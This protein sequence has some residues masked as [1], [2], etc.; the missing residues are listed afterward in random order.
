MIQTVPAAVTNVG[1][2]STPADM[3]IT[4]LVS[5]AIRWRKGPGAAIG[6][7]I[8]NSVPTAFLRWQLL[9]NLILARRSDDL[10]LPS[11]ATAAPAW[12][13]PGNFVGALR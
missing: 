8:L 13:S 9:R 12:L 1:P 7:S 4:M 11:F 10:I 2:S 6:V 5:P 3:V